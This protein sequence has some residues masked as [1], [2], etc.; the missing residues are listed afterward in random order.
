MPRP[1]DKGPSKARWMSMADPIHGIIQFD[2]HYPP[3]QLV[4]AVMNS[5]PMQRLRRIRQMGLAEF[6]FPNATHSRFVHS[7]GATHLMMEAL[8]VLQRDVYGRELLSQHYPGCSTKLETL[9]LL[10][11]L[12]HDVGHAPLSHTLEDLLDLETRGL[13]HDH[14][15]NRK[16]LTEDPELQAIWQHIDPNLPEALL[17]VMGHGPHAPHPSLGTTHEPEPQ[18]FLASLVSSQLD[19]DRLDYLLR[20]SHFLGFATATL[21]PNAL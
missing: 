7:V 1:S 4:L 3:H 8:A 12:V 9:L 13:S 19:M 17:S 2:R 15:W 18:H 10:A 16:I 11:I 6:V 21:K 5:G 14:Y 20:D